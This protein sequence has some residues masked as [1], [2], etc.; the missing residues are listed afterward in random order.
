[1]PYTFVGDVVELARQSDYLMVA[2][3]G[4]PETRHL[5]SRAV[6]DA[7]GPAS[8]LIN[9]ARG[10]VVDED[11]MIDALTHKRLGFAA[12]DVF[13]SEPNLR[14][15]AAELPERDCTAAPRHRRH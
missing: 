14:Q 11:A 1:M 4:G 5:V 2:C 10:S 6:I 3:K 7:A 15:A 8:T 13:E 9:V 12:L